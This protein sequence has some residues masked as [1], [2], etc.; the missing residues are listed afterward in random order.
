MHE[1]Y[2][3]ENPSCEHKKT[4]NFFDHTGLFH[5]GLN[6]VLTEHELDW[7]LIPNDWH[8]WESHHSPEGYTYTGKWIIATSGSMIWDGEGHPPGVTDE[9]VLKRSEGVA[10]TFGFR[11]SI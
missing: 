6:R 7:E 4:K 5:K 3:L 8:A 1:T 10:M 9:D 2:D 11:K